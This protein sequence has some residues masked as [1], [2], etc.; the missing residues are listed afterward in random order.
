MKL[1]R[2]LDEIQKYGIV[3]LL[4]FL[5]VWFAWTLATGLCVKLFLAVIVVANGIL[6]H[7]LSVKIS[8]NQ[9]MT[10]I[11]DRLNKAVDRKYHDE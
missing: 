1:I 3:V 2:I 4:G 10:K 8:V 6:L 9:A 5:G 11:I 7:M